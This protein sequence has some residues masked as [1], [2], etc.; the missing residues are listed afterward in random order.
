MVMAVL[1]IT[2]AALCALG[3]DNRR[4]TRLAV[5]LENLHFFGSGTESYAADHGDNIWSFWWRRGIQYSPQFGPAGDD[6]QA[7]ANQAVDIMRRLGPEPQLSQ[8]PW[9]MPHITT[10]HLVLLEH[11]GTELVIPQAASP[12]DRVLQSWQRNRGSAF[13]ELVNRPSG[14]SASTLRYPYYSSYELGPATW[15]RDYAMSINGVIHPAYSQGSSYDAFNVPAASAP[16]AGPPRR[17]DEVRFPADKAHMWDRYQRHFGP[18]VL[19]FGY[20][21]ARLP[22][23]MMDGSVGVRSISSANRGFRPSTPQNASPTIA[24]YAPD[25]N[26]EPPTRTGATSESVIMHLRFTR[27]GLRGRDFNGPEPASP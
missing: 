10:S 23:L 16:P 2:V 15:S 21:D 12:E 3:H 27:W 22:V 26:W 6:T 20:P 17:R 7:A 5:G 11:L 8:I 18:Q 4:R 25:T 14:F 19:Y 24:S 13:L 9:W 1:G